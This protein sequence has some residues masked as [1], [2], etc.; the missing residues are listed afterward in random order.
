MENTKSTVSYDLEQ[1][2]KDIIYIGKFISSYTKDDKDVLS[3]LNGLEFMANTLLA[4]V[5]RVRSYSY[6][7][8]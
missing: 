7:K 8:D 2:V 4:K 1:D 5:R 3:N 6:L